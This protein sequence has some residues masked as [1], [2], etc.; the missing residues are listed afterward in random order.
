MVDSNAEI[1]PVKITILDLDK[2][3]MFGKET[4]TVMGT[5]IWK[6]RTGDGSAPMIDLDAVAADDKVAMFVLTTT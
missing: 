1:P 6:A 4:F 2:E 5:C 3:G